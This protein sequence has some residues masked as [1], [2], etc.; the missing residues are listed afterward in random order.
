MSSGGNELSFGYSDETADAVVGELHEV[1]ARTNRHEAA[2]LRAIARCDL[3][4]VYRGDDELDMARWLAGELGISPW[5]AS[6]LV[7]AAQ[8]LEG[9]PNSTAAYERGQLST[10]QFVEL[11]RFATRATEDELLPWAIRSAPAAIR[12]RAD[13]E[14]RLREEDLRVV[15]RYRSFSWEWDDDRTRLS[16]WGSLPADHGARLIKAVDR[17]AAKMPVTPEDDGDA[18][19][20]PSTR[21]ARRADALVALAGA[22]I[23]SDQDADRSTVMVHAEVGT[24]LDR[25]RNGVLHGGLPLPPNAT[26]M[27]ACD[28]RVQTV[29]HDENGG[30]FHISSPGYV[31]PR[32]LRRQVQFRDDYRCTFPRCGRRG[33][34]D[35]HHIVPWPEGPTALSNLTVLC[36]SHHRLVHIH[37][38]HVQLREDGTTEW[39]RRDWTPYRPRAGPSPGGYALQE[40]PSGHQL[41]AEGSGA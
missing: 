35:V 9:L 11:A 36:R 6:R 17:L 12:A 24:I 15:D 3:N 13:R 39:F 41:L 38:W 29:L 32:W 16:I 37:G 40:H 25:D 31:V 21:D 4:R 28:A 8:A 5:K 20:P 23:A 22:A 19:D 34:T 1:N 14:L 7:T 27:E 10:D 33:F 26:D 2:R 30:I 18:S